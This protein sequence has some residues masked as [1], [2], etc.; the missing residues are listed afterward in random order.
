MRQIVHLKLSADYP[1]EVREAAVIRTEEG[2]CFALIKVKRGEELVELTAPCAPCGAMEPGDIEFPDSRPA[3][4]WPTG[5]AYE[6]LWNALRHLSRS[7]E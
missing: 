4:E 6:R 2:R 5:A 3:K 7:M 1:P